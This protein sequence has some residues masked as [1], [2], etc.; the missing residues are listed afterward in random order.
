MEINL[1]ME[2]SRTPISRELLKLAE[3][4]NI[5]QNFE[6]YTESLG[7]VLLLHYII[8]YPS[9]EISGACCKQ[10]Q[11]IELGL[12]S[13]LGWTSCNPKAELFRSDM[14]YTERTS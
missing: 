1:I 11:N 2:V 3:A 14:T 13:H 7:F 8:P 10:R 6:N 4:V 12:S 9:A 5:I